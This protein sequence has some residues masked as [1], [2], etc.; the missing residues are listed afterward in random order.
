MSVGF[1]V[2]DD[3]WSDD[4]MSKTVRAIELFD[5]SAVNM[6]ASPTTSISLDETAAKKKQL[7][8][9]GG[10]DGTQNAPYPYGGTMMG[11]GTGSRDKQ[12]WSNAEKRARTGGVER[13]GEP[14]RLARGAR[15]HHLG[16]ESRGP[17][18]RGAGEAERRRLEARAGSRRDERPVHRRRSP[19]S[20]RPMMNPKFA[21]RAACSPCGPFPSTGACALPVVCGEARRRV[22]GRLLQL[23]HIG[24]MRLG[25]CLRSDR[26]GRASPAKGRR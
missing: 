14:P 26:L 1:R 6:P 24:C 8:P 22:Q 3:S 13:R 20:R 9:E 25:T 2:I 5:V 15:L 11:D 19:P 7:F 10:P 18:R 17:R 12:R 4:W 21:A 23:P 16:A